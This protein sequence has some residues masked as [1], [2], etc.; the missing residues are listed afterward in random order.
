MCWVNL[1]KHVLILAGGGGHTGYAYALAQELYG[2]LDLSFFVPN[3][4]ALGC[5]R[6]HKFGK[7]DF[8][9]KPRGP[10]TPLWQFLVRFTKAFLE[11]V[12]KVQARH[13]HLDAI[14]CTGSNFCICPAV[15]AWIKQISIINIESIVRFVSPSK[16]TRLLQP[17]SK[18]TA[19]Q[20]QEQKRLLDGIVVGP[21]LPRIEIEP[22]NGNYI[23]VTGG[24]CGYKA[25]FDTL[26][27]SNLGNVVLHTGEVNPEPYVKNHPEW[28]VFS[29][30]ER[31]FQLL[32][33]ARLVVTH[34]GF[35]VAEAITYR[36]PVVL[37]PN[38]ELKRGAKIDDAKYLARKTNSVLV[39][40]LDLE[41]LLSA[42]DKASKRKIP[43][44]ASGTR[45]LANRIIKLIEIG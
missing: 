32:A 40:E 37:V 7:V 20:W 1:Q 2:K 6:L 15:L 42:I 31:F 12:K 8:L 17:F 45:I 38:P 3:G 25:L 16:T 43:T 39:S 21:L 14:V 4:D 11:S 24:T 44:I 5:H 41:N 22:W 13:E 19:L 10:K 28:R 23:L 26:A 30:T 34:L 18:I 27:Q 36:K 29:S 9:E 33:G 35:T